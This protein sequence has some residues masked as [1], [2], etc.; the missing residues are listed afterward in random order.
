MHLIDWLILLGTLG[1]IV[2]YG[3]WRTR[4]D[5]TSD[6]FLKGGSDNRWWA[7][8]LSV[9]ATQASAITFLST[10]GQG[11][12]DGLVHAHGGEGVIAARTGQ[13]Q[14]GDRKLGPQPGSA[15]TAPVTSMRLATIG[16]I[17][18]PTRRRTSAGR[19][20]ASRE[21]TSQCR[22]AISAGLRFLPAI[23]CAKYGLTCSHGRTLDT[24]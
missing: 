21:R 17:S 20:P 1:F 3:V 4:K 7:V 11:F 15:Q 14:V 5:A 8:G 23:F 18:A 24:S 12:L 10:P 13:Q 19:N 2:G 16:S 22:A 9:M 6:S